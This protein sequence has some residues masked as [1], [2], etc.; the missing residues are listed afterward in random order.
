MAMTVAVLYSDVR[1]CLVS[2]F[3]G[4]LRFPEKKTSLQCDIFHNH[5]IITVLLSRASRIVN[6]FVSEVCKLFWLEAVKVVVLY[7]DSLMPPELT[8]FVLGMVLRACKNL[9]HGTL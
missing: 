6:K 4:R 8:E 1:F 2:D 7:M 9:A 5:P 3:V